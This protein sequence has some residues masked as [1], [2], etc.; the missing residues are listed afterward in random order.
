M[1]QISPIAE[2]EATRLMGLFKYSEDQPRDDHGRFGE[3]SG[4]WERASGKNAGFGVG[5]PRQKMTDDQRKQAIKVIENKIGAKYNN[6]DPKRPMI[7]ARLRS[8][9]D[10][11][12][13]V[14]S[15]AVVSGSGAISILGREHECH[16]NA[17]RLYAAGKIDAIGTGYVLTER[18]L[19]TQHSWGMKDGKIVETVKANV[20]SSK[21]FGVVLNRGDA[22]AFVK[23]MKANPPSY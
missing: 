17:A 20:G 15:G 10:L 7:D 12:S 22:K 6:N 14:K 16:W 21:Y 1:T 9:P 8:D 18:N 3:S 19:W 13:L 4:V 2:Q 11:Q 5:V 23:C